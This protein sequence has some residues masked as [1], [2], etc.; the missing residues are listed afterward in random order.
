[1]I[2]QFHTEFDRSFCNDLHKD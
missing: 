1:M 2:S